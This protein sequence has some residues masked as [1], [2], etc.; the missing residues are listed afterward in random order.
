MATTAEKTDPALWEKVKAEVTAGAKGGEPGEWSARKAQLAVHDYKA[1]GGGYKGEKDSHNHLA[2]W[3]AERWGTKSGNDSH[4]T[5]ERYLPEAARDALTDEEYRRSTD[6]K[7]E[8]TRKGKQF[9]AQPK[10]IA[11]KTNAARKASH[12]EPTLAEL[13]KAATA[14][15]IAGR[16]KMSKEQLMK[17][18]R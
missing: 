4:E 16:S 2:E 10:D 11:A 7:R 1:A 12:G 18:V 15:G 5:G 13:K 8:D 17:A 3:T 6:K 14:K 9:S